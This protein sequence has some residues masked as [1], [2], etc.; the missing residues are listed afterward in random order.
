MNLSTQYLLLK[1]LIAVYNLVSAQN[2]SSNIKE[3]IFQYYD[4]DIR[5]RM[6]DGNAVPV[7]ID[8]ILYSIE[9]TVS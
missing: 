5:P 1:I 7:S 6:E 2:T 9:N 8:F 3:K 4:K